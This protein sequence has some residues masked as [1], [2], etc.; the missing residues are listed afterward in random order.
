MNTFGTFTALLLVGLATAAPVNDEVFHLTSDWFPDN[1]VVYTG[2][3]EI[4]NIVV[5]V[6][7]LNF[8]RDTVSAISDNIYIFFV[9]A[10]KG[11]FLLK[12]KTATKLLDNGN[13]ISAPRDHSKDVF[14]AASDGIY[15]FNAEKKTAEKYGSLTDNIISIEVANK[16]NEIYILTVDHILYK[17][18]EDGNHKEEITNVKDAQQIALDSF[19]NLYYVDSK[20]HMYAR[21]QIGGA[22]KK[23]KNLPDDPTYIKLLRPPVVLNH[24][25]PVIADEKGFMVKDGTAEI[26]E[27]IFDIKPTAYSVEA[28]LILYL[29]HNN[30]IYE[31]QL[32]N[33]LGM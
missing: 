6:N 12:N 30:K 18:T 4:T 32:L 27:I 21:L 13:Y 1:F 19:N 25:V 9:E 5:P 8:K 22:V 26:P 24:L 15:T 17:V 23:V 3:N 20:K 31:Y 29:G 7:T 10:N 33:I 14:F 16:T 28:S 2:E 11:I